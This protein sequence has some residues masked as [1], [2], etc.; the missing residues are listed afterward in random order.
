MDAKVDCA[1]VGDANIMQTVIAAASCNPKRKFR[2]VAPRDLKS[3]NG[4]ESNAAGAPSQLQRGTAG[5]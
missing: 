2:M 4:G 5:K 3:R 1:I